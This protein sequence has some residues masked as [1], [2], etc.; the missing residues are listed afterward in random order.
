MADTELESIQ[1]ELD[2]KSNIIA[3]R[4]NMAEEIVKLRESIDRSLKMFG[5]SHMF[6]GGMLRGA[7][8]IVGAT[9]FVILAG[10]ILKLMGFLPGLSDVANFLTE[11]FDRARIN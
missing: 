6:W 4:A 8:I 9:A 1:E 5:W 7:G 2:N 11:A 10:W 3:P